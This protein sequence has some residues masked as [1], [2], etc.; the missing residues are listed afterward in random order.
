[1]HFLVKY[2]GVVVIWEK[3]PLLAN[4]CKEMKG[5][6][7]CTFHEWFLGS[8]KLRCS[9]VIKMTWGGHHT[10]TNRHP[11]FFIEFV[12]P[13]V[14][15]HAKIHVTK[16]MFGW[17]IIT[18][19]R[20]QV[21]FNLAKALQ[22]NQNET[23]NESG[24]ARSYSKRPMVVHCHTNCNKVIYYVSTTDAL[25]F[26]RLQNV[27]YQSKFFESVQKFDCI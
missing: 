21:P 1:M 8:Y 25:S 10:R 14:I 20:L 6:E 7:F 16:H 11:I 22:Q 26:Y 19:S 5:V 12:T 15:F 4:D 2:C 17:T 18:K 23:W 3:N 27:L 24:S 13:N 9:R